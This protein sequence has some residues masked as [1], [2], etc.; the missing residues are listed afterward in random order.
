MPLEYFWNLKNTKATLNQRLSMTWKLKEWA[1][2]EIE[3]SQKQRKITLR[4]CSLEVVKNTRFSTK[5]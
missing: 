5:C 2:S 1:K 3:G 4:Q